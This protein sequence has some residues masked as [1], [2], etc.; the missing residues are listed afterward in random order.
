MVDIKKSGA[1]RGQGRPFVKGDPRI[2]RKGRPKGSRDKMSDALVDA[3]LADWMVH[4][5]DSIERVREKDP[6]TYVR[7]AFAMMPKEIKQEVEVTDQTDHTAEIERDV[8][9]GKAS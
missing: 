7:V 8:I 6:S 1:P 5:K 3:F 9:T 2:N 4:G